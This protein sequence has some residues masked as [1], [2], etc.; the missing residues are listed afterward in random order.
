MTLLTPASVLEK[1]RIIDDHIAEDKEDFDLNFLPTE[2]Q[3]AAQAAQAAERQQTLGRSN[4]ADSTSSVSLHRAPT[5]QSIVESLWS[6]KASSNTLDI[7][8]GLQRTNTWR[9]DRADSVV[10]GATIEEGR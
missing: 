10:G 8:S 4:T 3:Q 7:G 6:R 5:R 1:L 2:A 9:S